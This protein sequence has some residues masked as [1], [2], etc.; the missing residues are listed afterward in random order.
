MTIFEV[1]H[2]A[3]Q[4]WK[5]GRLKEAGIP[6]PKQLAFAPIDFER[7]SLLAELQASGFVANKRSFFIWLGV[8]PYLTREAVIATLTAIGELEGGGEV[9][10]SDPPDSLPAEMRALHAERAARVA[11]IGEPFLTYF[12]PPALH[13]LLRGLNLGV[14][15]DLGPRAIFERFAG[16]RGL[17]E[18]ASR[19][20]R[21]PEHGGHIILASS[22]SG[23]SGPSGLA[24]PG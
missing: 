19:G 21:L 13:Q 23:P 6:I 15:E 18:I 17:A 3:T 4:I 9:V 5:Q 24:P 8:V 2:P 16:A 20:R 7:D 22:P 11:A 12:E 1:D 14:A 10:Y